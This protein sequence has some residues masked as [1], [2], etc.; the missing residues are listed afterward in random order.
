MILTLPYKVISL[1]I[2]K[3]VLFVFI[4]GTIL[5]NLSFA[6][7]ASELNVD[8]LKSEILKELNTCQC[9]FWTDSN[10]YTTKTKPEKWKQKW[11]G[12]ISIENSNKLILA[13]ETKK[14]TIDLAS[15]YTTLAS[16]E[17]SQDPRLS[18]HNYR[19]YVL[20]Q[21][22]K[23]QLD[24]SV[25][26]NYPVDTKRDNLERYENS[27]KLKSLYEKLSLYQK[28]IRKV[29]YDLEI[30][31]FENTFKIVSG[32]TMITT[33]TEEQRKFAVQANALNEKMDYYNALFYY[34]KAIEIIPYSFPEAYYNMALI[35]EQIKKF[36]FAILCMKKYLIL[37]PDASDSRAA[38][39]KIYEWE[40]NLN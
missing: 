36:E 21:N 11:T 17:N 13:M 7:T 5:T 31:D 19:I 32:E 25:T 12:T 3:T 29:T 20:D 8:S 1:D 28:V 37:K 18:S 34:Q 9:E 40:L 33:I 24:I 30:Q 14:I 35:A 23:R 6:Q 38:Q 10:I 26:S 2:V 15:I 27:K 22:M 16:N 4:N 39:D